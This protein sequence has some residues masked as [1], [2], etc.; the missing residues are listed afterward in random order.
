MSNFRDPF[1]G[2]STPPPRPDRDAIPPHLTA[3]AQYPYLPPVRADSLGRV[4]G[5]AVGAIV[6]VVVALVL[7]LAVTALM[8]H[9]DRPRDD[10][11]AGRLVAVGRAYRVELGKVYG[12]AWLEGAKRLDDGQGPAAALESVAKAWDSGRVALFE[13]LVTP[14]LARVVPEG[15][16]DADVSPTDR[17][18]LAAAWRGFAKGLRSDQSSTAP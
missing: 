17:A 13:R 8:G 6:G 11:S 1:A 5:Y 16:P 4:A 2:D 7:V 9:W 15:K 3:T 14:E 12:D 18:K 10:P